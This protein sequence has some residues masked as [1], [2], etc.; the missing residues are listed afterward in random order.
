MTRV[1]AVLLITSLPAHQSFCG[2]RH[3][4]ADEEVGRGGPV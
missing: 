2:K 4:G 3:T 1:T